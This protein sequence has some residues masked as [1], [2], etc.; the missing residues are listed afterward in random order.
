M[1]GLAIGYGNLVHRVLWPPDC[2]GDRKRSHRC[3]RLSLSLLLVQGAQIRHHQTLTTILPLCPRTVTLAGLALRRNQTSRLGP[4]RRRG[5]RYPV[6][7]LLRS[8]PDR[9]EHFPSVVGLVGCDRPGGSLIVSILHGLH[10]RSTCKTEGFDDAESSS[11]IN[12][13]IRLTRPS[14]TSAGCS[15]HSRKAPCPGVRL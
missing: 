13:G 11:Y 15:V 1:T 12:L 3:A 7:H 4:A 8:F 14:R 2:T 10:R 9:L 5:T 6:R